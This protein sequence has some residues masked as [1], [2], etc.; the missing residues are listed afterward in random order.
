MSDE[1]ETRSP[2]MIEW[3]RRRVA[4]LEEENERLKGENEQFKVKLEENLEN[5]QEEKA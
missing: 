1:P 4:K 2:S 3:L 5:P